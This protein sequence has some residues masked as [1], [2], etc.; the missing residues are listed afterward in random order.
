M[1]GYELGFTAAFL[2]ALALTPLARHIALKF[3]AVDRPDGV[4]KLQQQPVPLW[5]GVA[6]Y[7]AFALGLFLAARI[8]P[9]KDAELWHL[10]HVLIAAAGF[11]CVMGCIDDSWDLKPRVKLCLQVCATLPI[12]AAGYY[13]ERL[14]MFGAPI[15]LGY[16]GIPL[17]VC[18]LVGCINALNLLDGMDGLAAVV[19]V[20]TAA[21]MALLAGGTGHP[22]VALI[23]IVFAGALAGFLLFNLP[24]ASIYLGDSGSMVIGLVVGILGIQGALKTS[25]TLSITAP[26]VAMSIP[27]LDTALAIVRRKL[28]GQPFDAADRGHIHHRL[29][30]R[31]LTNWQA[32][33]IV[34][35]L[36][37]TTGAAATA[38]TIFRNDA[39]AWITALT[40]G[41]V[42]VRTK[43]FGHYEF[44]LI[45]VTAA[46]ILGRL[47][48]RML[49]SAVPARRIWRR[50][51]GNLTVDEA[52]KGLVE[53][54]ARGQVQEIEFMVIGRQRE[55]QVRRWAASSSGVHGPHWD[56]S[57]RFAD[58]A[59][60][61]YELRVQAP[62]PQFL[63]PWH[64]LQLASALETLVR[65]WSK[66]GEPA[67]TLPLTERRE[68][69]PPTSTRQA[70]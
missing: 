12:V 62:G 26:V 45:K 23:A 55:P 16:F 41:V 2:A 68:E 67:V 21:M 7:V 14:V 43:A 3:D 27:M 48:D 31:G 36:C 40:L 24:P 38:A 54:A 56:W 49:G 25:A 6:V 8:Q 65:I 22:H 61:V 57:M 18:W 53:E 64:Q 33:W 50:R 51:R 39:L 58:T 29:L 63:E 4:R 59:G 35:A 70:A 10:S 69:D 9:V 46:M 5:G 13:V 66:D 42:L 52:W 17:T 1:Y 32:L 60:R 34:G 44:S 15:E 28:S 20:S 19:G 47:V 37:L 11:V 30:D